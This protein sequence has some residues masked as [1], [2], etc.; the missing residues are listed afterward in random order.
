MRASSSLKLA[1]AGK[2]R[3]P[4]GKSVRPCRKGLLLTKLAGD[5]A[6]GDFK[7]GAGQDMVRTTGSYTL[8]L[9]YVLYVLHHAVVHMLSCWLLHDA[10]GTC[11]PENIPERP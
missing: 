8:W 10:Y 7:P 5:T 11:L 9:T 3:G 2:S 6:W 1:K 4:L